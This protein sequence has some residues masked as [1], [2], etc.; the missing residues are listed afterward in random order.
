M[1]PKN[2]LKTPWAPIYTNFEGGARAEKN[3]V[4]LVN[5]AKIALKRLFCVF[6]QNFTCGAK[7]IWPKQVL[8][9]VS[10]EL[11]KLNL[12]DLKKKKKVD[13]INV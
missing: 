4:F 13:K 2:F 3:R 11:E 12:V 9:S 1:D 10:G 5:I 6:F 7:N 8:F